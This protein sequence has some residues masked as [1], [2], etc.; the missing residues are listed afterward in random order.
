[1]GRYGMFGRFSKL[2]WAA[3]PP[4]LKFHDVKDQN[5]MGENGHR[6][7]SINLVNRGTNQS[8]REGR[9]ITIKSIEIRAKVVPK[10]GNF[11]NTQIAANDLWGSGIGRMIVVLDYQCNGAALTHSQLME[12]FLNDR[13]KDVNLK[14][15]SFSNRFKIIK[16]KTFRLGVQS[17]EATNVQSAGGGAAT[18]TQSRLILKGIPYQCHWYKKCNIP[19]E[20]SNADGNIDVTQVRSNNILIFFFASDELAKP[21]DAQKIPQVT[22]DTFCRIRYADN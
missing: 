21:G 4:E 12:N 9:R 14:N 19:I 5:D 6:I 2:G 17:Y 15:I 8:Q 18:V 16:D 13:Y 7:G 3:A 22:C 10:G 11:D 20:Y 1:M